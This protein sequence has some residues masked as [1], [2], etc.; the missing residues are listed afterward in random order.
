MIALVPPVTAAPAAGSLAAPPRFSQAFGT[1]TLAGPY[2]VA[3][4]ARG[5]VWV[6]DTGH[7]RVVEFT[8]SGGLL[9]TFGSGLDQPEG[10]ATDAKGDV[11]VAD[12]GHDR[13]VEFSAGGRPLAAFGSAGSG[14]GQLDQPA[15]LAVSPA[16]HVYVADQGNSRIEEFSAAGAY[17]ASIPVATPAGVA[18]DKLGDVWV[19]SPSYA[20]GSSVDEFSPAGA[21]LRQFGT[22]QAGYGDLGNTGGIAAGPD[23]LL[24]VAQ[25][26]YGWVS[27]FR[28]D[29]SISTE[30]GLQPDPANGREDLQFPQSLA[31][32]SGGR[33][34]VAD[35]GNNRIA[36]FA[37]AS[38]AGL[39][40]EPPGAARRCR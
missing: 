20:P 14:H 1:G 8:A 10:I 3:T 24:Y 26:D 29:G 40:T 22:V 27:V 28:P 16:G 17:L 32:S 6:A 33:V 34:Y 37:G 25:P 7:N 15:A 5:D 38:P 30:F 13:V 2:G 19:S 4:D 39:P 18:L 12:T 9:A 11:W 23:G 21:K 36:E 35:D 31:I